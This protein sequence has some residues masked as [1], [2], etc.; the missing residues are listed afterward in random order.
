MFTRL[1]RLWRFT[2]HGASDQCAE[3]LGREHRKGS[4][5]RH[6]AGAFEEWPREAEK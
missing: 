6:R 4:V 1:N 5:D 2:V 3:D